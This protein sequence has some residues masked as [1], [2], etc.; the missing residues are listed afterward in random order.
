[1]PSL[2][3]IFFFSHLKKNK[4]IKNKLEEEVNSSLFLVQQ[5]LKQHDSMGV[6][7][8]ALCVFELNLAWRRGG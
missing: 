4:K 8:T 2:H 5:K 3:D 1:M 7:L 6:P